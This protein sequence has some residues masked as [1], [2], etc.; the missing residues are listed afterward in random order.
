MRSGY[1]F[2]AQTSDS[3]TPVLPPVYSTTAPPGFNRPSFSAASIMASAIR[4]FILPVGFSLSIFNKI[5][6]PFFGTIRRN[7]RSEVLPIQERISLTAFGE[8]RRDNRAT[9][10]PFLRFHPPCWKGGRFGL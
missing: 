6:A 1:P 7:A 4:S 8:R 3:E 2:T 5:R 9:A 10:R